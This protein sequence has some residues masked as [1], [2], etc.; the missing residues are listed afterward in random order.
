MPD[1]VECRDCVYSLCSYKEWNLDRRFKW[2]LY[3][4]CEH[5]VNKEKLLERMTYNLALRLGYRPWQINGKKKVD[6]FDAVMEANE[7]LGW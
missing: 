5:G 4:G 1:F 7:K 6:P 2:V 3:F